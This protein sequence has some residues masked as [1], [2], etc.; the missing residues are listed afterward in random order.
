MMVMMMMMICKAMNVY[1]RLLLG[2]PGSVW[3]GI[4]RSIIAVNPKILP[5]TE[6][7][8]RAFAIS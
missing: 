3:F 7:V 8:K 2:T 1:R 5:P 6:T 4:Q